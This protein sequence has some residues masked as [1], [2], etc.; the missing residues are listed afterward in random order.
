MSVLALTPSSAMASGVVQTVKVAAKKAQVKSEGQVYV[1][2]RSQVGR[3]LL[4]KALNNLE[5]W[6]A[7]VIANK[8]LKAVDK[9]RHK[10]VVQGLLRKRFSKASSL[11]KW[12][13]QEE[14]TERWVELDPAAGVLSYWIPVEKDWRLSTKSRKAIASITSVASILNL[15]S[16]P[17]KRHLSL[18]SVLWTQ[19]SRNHLT[20]QIAFV[21]EED[22][23]KVNRVLHFQADTEEDFD[24]WVYSLSSYGLGRG[25]TKHFE[26]VQE[27]IEEGQSW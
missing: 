17:R 4:Q 9:N 1:S 23:R 16:G 8:V 7:G 24:M 15:N 26:A 20:F 18:N 10:P 6:Q 13:C 25:G 11:W 3:A 19:A 2:T 27:Q 21:E 5:G 14:W 22:F 12:R